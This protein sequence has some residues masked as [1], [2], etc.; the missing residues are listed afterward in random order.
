MIDI[1]KP[2]TAF[3]RELNS[4]SSIIVIFDLRSTV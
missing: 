2:K 1:T 4:Y 3:E